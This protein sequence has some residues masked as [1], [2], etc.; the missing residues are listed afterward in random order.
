MPFGSRPADP[1]RQRRDGTPAA[2]L[3]ADE[4]VECDVVVVGTGAGGAVVARE[5]A[6]RGHAVVMIEEGEFFQRSDF[7]GRSVDMQ[8]RL[9]RDMGATGSIGNVGIPIP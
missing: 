9:Y 8:R 2:D 3:T 6:E 4:E 5:L 7:N 1:D